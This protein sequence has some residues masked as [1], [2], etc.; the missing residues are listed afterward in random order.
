MWLPAVQLAAG[1][2]FDLVARP[3]LDPRAEPSAALAR[4]HSIVSMPSNDAQLSATAAADTV[5]QLPTT[6][7]SMMRLSAWLR[8]LESAQ[9]LFDPDVSYFIV[10][11]S[12]I[13]SREVRDRAIVDA[14]VERLVG[15]PESVSYWRRSQHAVVLAD[16]LS[17]IQ[18]TG[19]LC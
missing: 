10:T 13:S 4:A 16:D 12:S 15:A 8:A 3:G 2:P 5:Q 11:A 7:A 17:H 19:M 6:D 1:S 14:V 9:H 18:K